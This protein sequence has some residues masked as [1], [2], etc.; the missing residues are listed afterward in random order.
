VPGLPKYSL[1][2]VRELARGRLGLI[3]GPAAS[4][5]NP[6]FLDEL[7]DDLAKR[8]AVDVCPTYHEVG[9][10]AF[11]KGVE[12]KLIKGAISEFA[13]RQTGAPIVTTLAS[14]QWT[15]VISGCLDDQFEQRLQQ[16]HARRPARRD[17]AIISDPR[18]TVPSNT[19]PVFKLLGSAQ[20]QNAA[21]TTAELLQRTATLSATVRE[22]LDQ[23]KASPILC[24]GFQGAQ[25]LLDPLLAQLYASSHRH[26]ASLVFLV[27]DPI[28][29]S[30]RLAQ[31]VPRNGLFLAEG[32]LV[33]VA[34]ALEPRAKSGQISFDYA[35]RSG[36]QVT[37][38]LSEFG[39]LL[40]VVNSRVTPDIEASERERLL[41]YLFMPDVPNWN[42]IA[43]DLDLPRT[44]LGSL[45]ES[46]IEFA[47]D[48][49]GSAVFLLHGRA[50]SGK[51]SV[52]KRLAFNLAEQG[53]FVCWLLDYRYNDIGRQ[54]EG[55][56]RKAREIVG[57][58]PIVLF[59]DSPAL[60]RDFDLTSLLSTAERL[61]ISLLVVL[62]ART[63]DATRIGRDIDE[64]AGHV[65]FK[66]A[67]LPDVLDDTEWT[68]LPDY[69][70]KVGICGTLDEATAAVRVAANSK[71]TRD[72]LALLYYLLPKTR[73]A[74][75]GS[76]RSEYVSLGDSE[77]LR[78][79][80]AGSFSGSHPHLQ[81]AYGMVAASTR[82]GVSV[83]AEV[84]VNA[85]R[86]SYT[87]WAESVDNSGPAWGFLYPDD[88]DDVEG[89][90]YRTRNAVV[91]DI[92]LELINGS[93]TN[94]SG[95]V[96][97]LRKLLSACDSTNPVYEKFCERVLIPN[98]NLTGLDLAQGLELYEAAERA[99]PL[100]NRAILHHKGIWIRK[101]GG[102]LDRALQAFD[103][104]LV[105]PASPHAERD[106]LD[107]F[108]HTSKAAAIVDKIDR[109]LVGWAEGQSDAL[110]ELER[111]RSPK[112]INPNA[113]H[114]YAGL[115]ERL[116]FRQAETPEVDQYELINRALAD[117]DK[118][119]I[120]VRS[121]KRVGL[122]ASVDMLEERRAT[123]LSR[124][125]D[126]D[127]G[128][129]RV[130]EN[131]QVRWGSLSPHESAWRR[132]S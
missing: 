77:S 93:H 61:G 43:H 110:K 97:K 114:V 57:S 44:L 65:A 63:S 54:L 46:V 59:I 58:A 129:E 119:L 92:V 132:P 47:N 98:G 37:G 87:E 102:D 120:V 70:L 99:L 34:R 16:V 116:A 60:L 106:E 101:N 118:T 71:Q 19:L 107:E 27:D 26:P 96:Q 10:L 68:I 74:I 67:E 3:L 85:L 18:D 5:T 128:A 55:A 131:H 1:D 90:R 69:L 64:G 84:L 125:G 11:A 117:I 91:T 104:A 30:P 15:A 49:S 115:V 112:F 83:P 73:A 35:A 79:I 39:D 75:E 100:R 53:M 29:A 130:W 4:T 45:Q 89:A 24:A 81:E 76:I 124:V 105:A 95:E 123:L 38:D 122:R 41:D 94:R 31:L 21:A 52:L 103:E 51:T 126:I 23:I 111:S 32:S 20:H 28:A 12:A 80:M 72:S 50:A 42:P 78:R 13:A 36:K 7:R 127:S 109:G 40:C 2:A 22:F 56:F 14:L 86:V 121:G 108:I 17:V 25:W 48:E 9:E 88:A 66:K 6:R 33:E 8:F 62:G 113:V 82:Y